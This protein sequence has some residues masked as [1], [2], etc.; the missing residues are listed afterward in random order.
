MRRLAEN[1]VKRNPSTGQVEAFPADTVPP[2]WVHDVISP[3]SHVWEQDTDP[4]T[5]SESDTGGGSTPEPPPRAGK[6]SGRDAWAAYA[7]SL[8]FEV[9]DDHGRD[10]I[11]AAIEAAGLT[12]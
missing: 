2:G 11:I 4:E 10:Q 1:I 6:G 3:D 8:G 7:V 12:A 9:D 5:T